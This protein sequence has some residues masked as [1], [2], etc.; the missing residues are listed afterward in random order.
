ML[1]EGAAV[2]L[3][4]E[5]EACRA[6]GAV[7]LAELIGYGTTSDA[8]RVTDEPADA[9][10]SIAAMRAAIA[11]AGI[12]QDAVDYVHAHGTAT[13]MNDRTESLAI[14]QVFGHH[15][16]R[17]PVSSSKSMIGHLVAA[18]GSVQLVTSILA[19]RNNLVPPTINY[20]QADPACDLDYVPNQARRA[21]LETVMSNCFGF[22]GQNACLIARKM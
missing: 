9:R 18:A 1:G 17:L 22:G 8:H 14:R 10:G 16:R 13:Q 4:E 19:L 11:D 5:L 2:V 12:S 20:Q 15:A 3:L 21:P 6:R 7:P